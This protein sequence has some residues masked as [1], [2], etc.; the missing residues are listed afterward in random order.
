MAGK[1]K[2]QA[3][4]DMRKKKI[5]SVRALR[6]AEYQAKI[7]A[8]RNTKTAAKRLQQRRKTERKVLDVKSKSYADTIPA[9]PLRHAQRYVK[10]SQYA[11]S[12]WS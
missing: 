4:R 6:Q 9:G 11:L 2:R 8:G 10:P 7:A 12:F 5:A 3:A 1:A